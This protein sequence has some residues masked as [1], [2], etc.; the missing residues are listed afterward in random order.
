MRSRLVSIVTVQQPEHLTFLHS[1]AS[2]T[3]KI[4]VPRFREAIVVTVHHNKPKSFLISK[5]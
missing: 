2:Y 5:G 1:V 4:I 3:T